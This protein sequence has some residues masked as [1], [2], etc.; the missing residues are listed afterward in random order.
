MPWLALLLQIEPMIPGLVADFKALFAK[1]PTLSDPTAQAA[2]IAAV[3]SAAS[4]TDD[5]TLAL[6]AADQAKHPQA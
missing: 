6:I 1:H 5:A 4:T 2:F 3:A